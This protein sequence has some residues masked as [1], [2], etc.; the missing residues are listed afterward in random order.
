M[1]WTSMRLGTWTQGGEV[2]RQK[3]TLV[4]ENNRGWQS[5]Q[6]DLTELYLHTTL[7]CRSL[8]L[9]AALIFLLLNLSV[10]N[11]GIW[12]WWEIFLKDTHRCNQHVV[13]TAN[14]SHTQTYTGK[15]NICMETDTQQ[16]LPIS[17]VISSSILHCL[18][19]LSSPPSSLSKNEI[20]RKK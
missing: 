19:C 10:R 12:W 2:V 1:E 9:T 4:E 5:A 17:W 15:H 11:R 8:S 20:E 18:C 3:Y 14:L 13:F 16:C 6:M 7:L